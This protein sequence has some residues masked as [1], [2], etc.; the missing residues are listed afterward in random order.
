MAVCKK[1]KVNQNLNVKLIAF[2]VS[3]TRLPCNHLPICEPSLWFRK[4]QVPTS[5]NQTLSWG[6]VYSQQ[7][8]NALVTGAITRWIQCFLL[9]SGDREQSNTT[10]VENNCPL[11]REQRQA[12]ERKRIQLSGSTYS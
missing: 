10:V 5:S 11:Q 4:E 7:E 1:V 2:S 3:P 12:M 9:L 8:R 6:S